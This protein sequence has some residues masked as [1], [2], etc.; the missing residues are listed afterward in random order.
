[1]MIEYNKS[2]ENDRFVVVPSRY[3]YILDIKLAA[4]YYGKAITFYI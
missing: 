3:T 2:I 4:P 1:M